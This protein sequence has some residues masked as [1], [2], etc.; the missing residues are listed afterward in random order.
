MDAIALAAYAEQL[1]PRGKAA[2]CY[3]LPRSIEWTHLK[4]TCIS[5]DHVGTVAKFHMHG[6]IAL[7]DLLS[8]IASVS[9]FVVSRE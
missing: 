2:V 6:F 5:S 4:V 9:R 7:E 1:L 3:I 8:S